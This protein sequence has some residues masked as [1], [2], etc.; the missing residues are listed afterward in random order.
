MLLVGNFK[1][2][3][4][5]PDEARAV[6]KG[7]GRHTKK[8]TVVL[9]PS[10]V[11]L[12]VLAAAKT[13][14]PLA[15][16]DV[17]LFDDGAHTGE[18][19]AQSI[20]ASGV[21]HAIVGH[22]ERRKGGETNDIV[23][24]KVAKAREAGLTTILCVGEEERD[25]HAHYLSFITEQITSALKGIPEKDFKSILIAYEPIWAIGKTAGDAITPEHL[26]ETLLFIKK[27]LSEQISPKASSIRILYGGS[28]SAENIQSLVVPYLDGFLIGRASATVDSLKALISALDEVR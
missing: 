10:F 19:S 14:I 24:T 9:A 17:S 23:A 21:T 28:V 13:K 8:H 7:I 4:T 22:S 18:V 1:S 3:H 20:A 5:H 11:H 2:Y 6:A 27:I 26:E 25:V 15:A 12:G 16:Q